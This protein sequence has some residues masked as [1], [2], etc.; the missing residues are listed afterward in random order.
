MS[1]WFEDRI[2]INGI[3]IQYYRTGGQKPQLLLLH[4]FTDN[5]LCWTPVARVLEHD[6]DIIMP[7]VRG[8]GL[9]DGPESGF[10]TDLL[11]SDAV[12]VIQ[13]LDLRQPY[14]LGH[15]MGAHTA[16]QLASKRPEL[17]RAVLLEDPPWTRA[18]APKPLSPARQKELEDE[19]Y[20]QMKA[21]QAKIF[22]ERIASIV[23]EH[24]HW[25]EEDV[26]L[27]EEANQQFNPDVL[28]RGLFEVARDWLV[29]AQH[30]T[31]PTLLI[32]ADPDLGALVTPEIA[33]LAV[34][35][36]QDGRVAYIAGAGH[37]IHREQFDSF[38]TVVQQFLTEK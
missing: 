33:Q 12:A 17:M 37:S 9:S 29:V 16:A 20:E 8:H 11:V 1:Q 32:T 30:L 38:M 22:D 31:C 24:P 26:L 34:N 21:L 19:R 27:K 28:K 15:S 35:S 4:G 6:Y 2:S 23:A 10:S 36:W 5:A 18:I 14:V 3:H 13:A 25:P 7:D